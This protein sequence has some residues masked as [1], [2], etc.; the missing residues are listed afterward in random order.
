MTC[1]MMFVV[2]LSGR[3]VASGVSVIVDP[4][5]ARSATRSHATVA[6]LRNACEHTES[7]PR[8]SAGGN[9]LS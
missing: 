6:T 8:E 5:G 4:A 7:N 9:L 3:V 1:A 2:P